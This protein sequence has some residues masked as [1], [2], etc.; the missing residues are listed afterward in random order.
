[1][2]GYR[3]TVPALPLDSTRAVLRRYGAVRP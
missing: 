2:R 1:V 3:G